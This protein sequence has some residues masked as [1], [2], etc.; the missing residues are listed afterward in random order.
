MALY[1]QT[2]MIVFNAFMLLNTSLKLAGE[3]LHLFFVCFCYQPH[4]KIEK[5]INRF[6]AIVFNF[7]NLM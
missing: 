3:K 7:V 4:L 5:E 2:E 6:W 1:V